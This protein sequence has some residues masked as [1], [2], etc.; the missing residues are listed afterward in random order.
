MSAL[1]DTGASN[2][3]ISEEGAKKLGLRVEKTKGRLKTV[4][5]EEVPTC[6]IARDVSIRMGQWSGKEIVEVIPLDDYAFVIGMDFLD[7]IDALILPF[8]DCICIL[9]AGCQCI[10]PVK[11]STGSGQKMLSAMQLTRG[12][13]KEGRGDLSR[14]LLRLRAQSGYAQQIPSLS[15]LHIH[16]N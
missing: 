14:C 4:N 8:A 2:L 5:S 3:F 13:K 15:Y 16:R 6:G 7:R 1:V 10:V 12:V 9:D 11:R